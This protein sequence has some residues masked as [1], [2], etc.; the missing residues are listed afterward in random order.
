MTTETPCPAQP[1]QGRSCCHLLA[2]AGQPAPSP[3]APSGTPAHW[4][5]AAPQQGQ[6]QALPSW[7]VRWLQAEPRWQAARSRGCGKANTRIP[8]LTQA[9]GPA[10]PKTGSSQ[11][12]PHR[13]EPETQQLKSLS[14]RLRGSISRGLTMPPRECSGPNQ[15]LAH[16]DQEGCQPLQ[17]SWAGPVPGASGLCGTTPSTQHNK[18]TASLPFPRVG[19]GMKGFMRVMLCRQAQT[20]C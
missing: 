8:H 6:P 16:E 11:R 19:G 18:E 10:E 3:P 17:A 4:E 1:S 14:E 13:K 20:V 9:P 15:H 7:T 12:W 5:P 2:D